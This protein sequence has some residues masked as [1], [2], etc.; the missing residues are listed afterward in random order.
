MDF[1]IN[2]LA[3]GEGE[4][5]G[6]LLLSGEQIPADTEKMRVIDTLQKALTDK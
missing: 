5:G 1:G 4:V 3:P 2:V 6:G